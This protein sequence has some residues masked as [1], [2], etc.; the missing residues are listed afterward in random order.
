MLIAELFLSG[1]DVEHLHD[2]EEECV[3]DYFREKDQRFA[4]SSDERIRMT[5]ERSVDTYIHTGCNS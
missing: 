2:F 4:T 5:A 1:E 3:E